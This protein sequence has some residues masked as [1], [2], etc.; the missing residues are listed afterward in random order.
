[1]CSD[2]TPKG[3]RFYG[4]SVSGA[5]YGGF[6]VAPVAVGGTQEIRLEPVGSYSLPIF[7][8]V[9]STG[10]FSIARISGDE[11]RL[12]GQAAGPRFLRILDDTDGGTLLDRVELEAAV[13]TRAVIGSVDALA[14]YSAPR[15]RHAVFA[16]GDHE[17]AIHLLDAADRIVVDSSMTIAIADGSV[18]AYDART[19][20]LVDTDLPVGVDAAGQHFDI[21]VELAPAIDGMELVDWLLGTSDDGVPSA[22]RGDTVCVVGLASE[23]WVVG[24][25]ADASFSLDG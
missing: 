12:A 19:V 16:P 22:A 15:R 14:L 24:Q 18:D 23:D 2:A 1:I 5:L 11:V 10:A 7:D 4:T 21:A 9:S 3:L 8:A 20:T 25:T 17:I 13:V 6:G